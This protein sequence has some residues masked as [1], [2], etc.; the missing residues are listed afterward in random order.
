MSPSI[1]QNRLLDQCMAFNLNDQSNYK[2]YVNTLQQ[3]R[4]TNK[5][6]ILH[7]GKT[8][9]ILITYEAKMS[10]VK[11]HP[12]DT[13]KSNHLNWKYYTMVYD[14]L[15][16]FRY[17]R[18]ASS[19]KFEIAK[20]L[21]TYKTILLNLKGIEQYDVFERTKKSISDGTSPGSFDWE[22]LSQIKLI[23]WGKTDIQTIN[24]EGN[25]FVFIYFILFIIFLFLF[26][27]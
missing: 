26:L 16:E 8:S 5:S 21:E 19:K 6:A 22:S 15:D 1:A 4:S 12:N 14:L 13:E 23:D 27:F 10:N 18:D 11:L 3:L 2:E 20:N 9:Q 7:V 24:I 17:F 25:K